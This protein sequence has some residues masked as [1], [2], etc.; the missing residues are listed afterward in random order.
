MSNHENSRPPLLVREECDA[1]LP[2]CCI[3]AM[4][5][6]KLSDREVYLSEIDFLSKICDNLISHYHEPV[7][8]VIARMEKVMTEA[9][10]NEI[11]G[12]NKKIKHLFN[13]RKN[14]P[15]NSEY[16]EQEVIKLTTKIHILEE[17][18][19][20]P[21]K[22]TI[23]SIICESLDKAIKALGT[24]PGNFNLAQ[25]EYHPVLTKS[26]SNSQPNY[27]SEPSKHNKHI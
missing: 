23:Q 5:A 2:T 14:T 21:V 26:G 27:S 12:I 10:N 1:L 3:N 7:H 22:D 9:H 19:A 25:Y 20:I 16:C 18:K 24:D 6:H 4:S 11:E 17:R 15:C 8:S 13:L